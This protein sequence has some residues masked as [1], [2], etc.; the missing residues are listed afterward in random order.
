VTTDLSEEAI[1]ALAIPPRAIRAAVLA[2]LVAQR[3]NGPP[4]VPKFGIHDATGGRFHAM[5]AVHADVAVVKWIAVGPEPRPGAPLVEATM[6]VSDRRTGETVAR[7]GGRWITGVRTAAVSAL[8]AAFC[9]PPDL[10]DIAILGT[11]LQA[12]HH[13]A[14]LGDLFPLRRVRVMG[15]TP[16]AA[17]TFATA[18]G[19]GPEILAACRDEAVRSARLLVVATPIRTDPPLAIAPAERPPRS[20]LVS[21]DH[22][23]CLARDDGAGFDAILT[24]ERHHHDGTIAN[25]L[26]PAVARLDGDLADLALD[27]ALRARAGAGRA[28]FVPPGIALAD[29]AVARLV[30]GR[31]GVMSTL[32]GEDT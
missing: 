15:R 23:A 11:G 12:R 5:P 20:L 10:D 17:R 28:L 9:A 13:I 6:I 29:A 30:L 7:L 25:G 14:A 21:L 22:G 1:E 16:E 2:A 32:A 24:D 3:R 26:M 18:H 4:L 27:P 19:E 8:A 31:A